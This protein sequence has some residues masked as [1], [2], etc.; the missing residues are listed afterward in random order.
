MLMAFWKEMI[1]FDASM[2][3]SPFFFSKRELWA[4]AE[5]KNA[6]LNH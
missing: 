4:G 3:F 1:F 5:N 2:N 6:D